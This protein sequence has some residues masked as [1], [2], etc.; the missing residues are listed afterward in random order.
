MTHYTFAPW[1]GRD[2]RGRG[3][4]GRRLLILGESHY[5]A[6]ERD[7]RSSMTSEIIAD[8]FDPNSPHEGYKN[9]YTKC[10]NAVAGHSLDMSGK[11]SFWHSVAFYNYVQTAISGARMSP[12]A[13]EFRASEALFWQML[14]ELRPEY[15]LVWGY[16]LYDALP[17]GGYACAPIIYGGAE[18]ATWVYELR[19]GK[20]VRFLRMKHPS[21]GFSV[22]EWHEVIRLFLA[23]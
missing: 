5:C 10:A 7:V 1:V 2:Y 20:A 14:E 19:D 8:L 6:D 4:G 11:E 9:T 3:F 12:S 15:V 17:R 21:T 23:S 16:R 18:Y 13:E 22:D